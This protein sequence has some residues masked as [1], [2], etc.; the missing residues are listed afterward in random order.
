MS[1]ASNAASWFNDDAGS[2]QRRRPVFRK[3]LRNVRGTMPG[4][5]QRSLLYGTKEGMTSSPQPS[6]FNQT[7]S[8]KGVT[9]FTKKETMVPTS[10]V[11]NIRNTMASIEHSESDGTGLADFRPPPFPQ[12]VRVPV[13]Q[14]EEGMATDTGNSGI[15]VTDSRSA[16]Y[17]VTDNASIYSI[18]PTSKLEDAKNLGMYSN[19]QSAYDARRSPDSAF[20]QNAF[21][22]KGNSYNSMSNYAPSAGAQDKV[23]EKLNHL[24]YM[25]EDQRNERTNNVMQEVIL[26]A[27]IGIFT[28]FICDTFVRIGK[29]L[30]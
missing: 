6:E 17:R 9:A 30:H 2:T 25:M 23:V 19:Y 24:I 27:Y 28:I 1:L 14:I 11:E 15:R 22:S 7:N 18:L 20:L 13:D 29:V 8:M 16:D 3:T 10:N 5:N 26:F 12:M 21:G 4:E